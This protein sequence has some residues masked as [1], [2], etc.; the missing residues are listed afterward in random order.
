MKI[1][2]ATAYKYMYARRNIFKEKFQSEEFLD[3]ISAGNEKR[4]LHIDSDTSAFSN[5]N[6]FAAAEFHTN[7]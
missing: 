3:F 1:S 2:R 5:C 7:T 6:L 4:P